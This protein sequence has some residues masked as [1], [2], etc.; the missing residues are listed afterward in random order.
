MELVISNVGLNTMVVSYCSM[1]TFSSLRFSSLK[2]LMKVLILSYLADE[3]LVHR[4]EE[5]QR[6]LNSS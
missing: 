5:D 1:A 2:S 3:F 6:S 4:I